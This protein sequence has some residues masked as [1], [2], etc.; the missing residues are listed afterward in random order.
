MVGQAG[1]WRG[2]W[3]AGRVGGWWQAG[4]QGAGGWVVGQVGWEVGGGRQAGRVVDGRQGAERVGT[5]SGR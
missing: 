3:G 4:R 5:H 1:C 2:G